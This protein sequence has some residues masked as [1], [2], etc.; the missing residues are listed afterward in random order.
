MRYAVIV[1]ADEF[2]G[3]GTVL[4]APTSASARDLKSVDEAL[5][6]AFGL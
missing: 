6:L 1:P 4:V 5:M 3:L 2:L